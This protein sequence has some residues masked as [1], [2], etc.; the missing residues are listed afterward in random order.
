M[1]TLIPSL[2]SCQ[3]RMNS[4]EKRFGQRLE[5]LVASEALCWYDVACGPR[6]QQPDFVVLHPLHG[7]L[8]LELRD[9][10]LDQILALG[11]LS[12]SLLSK[13]G[14][15]EVG[16]PLEQA[17]QYA[18]QFQQVL[19]HDPLLLTTADD[20]E[21]N[22]L[23]CPPGYGLVLCNI[24]R[25][26]F[27]SAT[28]GVA[29]PTDR[30][31]CKDEMTESADATE[32]QQRLW[33]MVM[34]PTHAPLDAQ[35]IDRIR[36]HLFP[37]LRI[38][39]GSLFTGT[40]TEAT[41][42]LVMDLVQEQLARSLGDGHRVI[43]GVAG[44]GKTLILA[45]RCSQLARHTDKPILVLC[46]NDS[47]A[48][49]LEQLITD[50]KLVGRIIVRPFHGWCLDQLRL[51]RIH[52]PKEGP[53]F[54]GKLV[55]AVTQG[56]SEQRIPTGQYGA[57]LIDEGHDFE[58]EWFKLLS[59]MVDPSSNSLLLLYD[60]AQSIY[61]K[62]RSRDFSFAKVG[63]QARGRTTILRVNYRN[64]AEVLDYAY[65]FA[66]EALTPEENTEDEDAVPFVSPQSAGRAGL[67]PELT[68][69]L[70]LQDEAKHIAQQLQD[71]H[72]HGRDW[73]DMA[74][75][76]PTREVGDALAQ[77]LRAQQL[78]VEWLPQT[79]FNPDADSIKLMT[80]HSSKGLEF[81]IVAI[82]GL[83]FMPYQEDE[84]MEDTRLLYIGM[85]R[86]VERLILTAHRSSDFVKQL[87]MLQPAAATL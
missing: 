87:T 20:I 52:K 44:S 74:V 23:R 50:R 78:P 10:T 83:G 72:S 69:C 18:R 7:L 61:G 16:N 53:G 42:P 8:V 51:H 30:V 75:L 17:R 40:T 31:I 43:H 39:Q 38:Q 5:A 19:E 28:F 46:Y 49:K 65:R 14:C 64:T 73:K 24:T 57:V 11:R 59:Q 80:L 48:A 68:Q 56:V 62:K 2:S 54:P 67:A 32:F 79:R 15:Q 66:R 12:V 71:L 82:A 9:W 58:P 26:E 4:G 60:D 36:Y 45:Y 77:E 84:V 25:K 6:Y 29:L 37:D 22:I 85:T 34:N 13:D 86:A 70:T 1:A 47:L 41:A 33:A 55:R 3:R 76:Y 81:P 21:P 63:I 27:N 35:Q